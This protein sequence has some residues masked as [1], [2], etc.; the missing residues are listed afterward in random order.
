[1]DRASIVIFQAAGID[2]LATQ[3]E[4]Q[5]FRTE[6]SRSNFS[7]RSP[8]TVFSVEKLGIPNGGKIRREFRSV[9]CAI[10]STG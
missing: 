5:L 10:D 8:S 1:M 7:L 4:Q 6:N 3:A 9:L 2:L